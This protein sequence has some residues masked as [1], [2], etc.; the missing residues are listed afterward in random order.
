MNSLVQRLGQTELGAK[1]AAIRSASKK[2][3]VARET[4]TIFPGM[5][6][7][8]RL[9]RA[10]IELYRAIDPQ[11]KKPLWALVAIMLLLPFLKIVSNITM[12]WKKWFRF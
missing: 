8:A 3:L 10:D 9:L 4:T 1:L 5:A 12:F 11:G 6:A 2:F 7:F